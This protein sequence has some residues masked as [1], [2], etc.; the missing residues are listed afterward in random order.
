MKLN[1]KTRIIASVVGTVIAGILLLALLNNWIYTKKVNADLEKQV[2][3]KMDQIAASQQQ[4]EDYCLSH[5]VLYSVNPTVL[6][7]Y[8]I[9]RQGNMN[10]QQDD[11][12]QEARGILKAL[13]SPLAATYTDVMGRETYDVHFHLPT[14]RSL[15]RWTRDQKESDDLS[16]FRHTIL[17]ICRGDHAPIRGIE[18]GRGGFVIRGIAPIFSGKDYLG[19]VELHSSFEPVALRAKADNDEN[20]AVYMNAD[21]LEIATRLADSKKYPV[22][23]NRYVLVA[24]T[25]RDLAMKLISE[26]ILDAGV[27]GKTSV[28]VGSQQVSAFPVKDFSGKQI[29]VITY[30]QDISKEQKVLARARWYIGLG[31]LLFIGLI[32]YIV[33][34]IMTRSVINP[35]FKA[36]EFS[37]AIAKGDLNANVDID[38]QDEIGQLAEAMRTITTQLRAIVGNIIASADTVATSSQEMAAGAQKIAQGA[39]EQAASAEEASASME[40]MSS[41]IQQNSD[42]AKE[43]DNIAQR[44]ALDMLETNKAVAEAVS[45]MKEIAERISI[46][47]EIARQTDLLALNAAIEAARAGEHGRG[48]AVVASEVRKLA[49][50]SQTAAGEIGALSG[51]SVAVAERAGQMLD[52]L[53]PDIQKTAEL[54]Q[55]ISAASLEQ[56]KGVEQINTAIQQLDTVTQQT[57][58]GVEQMHATSDG[59]ATQARQLQEVIRYFKI[60]E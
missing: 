35:I 41:T 25:D 36:V 11:K 15:Q 43:T 22:I 33:T 42:N 4:V 56:T 5:A 7:A 19:S 14:C 20:V 26:K 12:V 21:L 55:E 24:E 46:I 23:A 50:R 28:R 9:A 10:T 54:V 1:L 38:Q 39:T 58:A 32:S 57:A 53:V 59:L 29:G 18:V 8:A 13:I 6:E 17:Q 49:E 45:A 51:S 48:F 31:S 47:Q 27:N 60:D 16:G 37:S 3:I 40:E 44:S 30:F 2:K 52:K 34:R